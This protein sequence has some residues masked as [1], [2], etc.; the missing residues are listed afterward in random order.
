[1]SVKK[2]DIIV[3][4]MIDMRL[5]I[6]NMKLNDHLDITV[7]ENIE[8]EMITTGKEMTELN[9]G[10]TVRETIEEKVIKYSY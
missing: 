9:V 2:I 1:M 3:Q 7:T 8:I 4:N 5:T 6:Q 10:I